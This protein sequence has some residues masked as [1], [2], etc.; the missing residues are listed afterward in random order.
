MLVAHRDIDRGNEAIRGRRLRIVE[1][2]D[3]ATHP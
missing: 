2:V 1:V 3:A